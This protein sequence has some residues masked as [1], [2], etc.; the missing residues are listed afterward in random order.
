VRAAQDPSSVYVAYQYFAQAGLARFQ[1]S[2]P[3]WFSVAK[4]ETSAISSLA[5]DGLRV[6][7]GTPDAVLS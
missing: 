7:V 2:P 3:Q 4:N 5:A 1:K 6:Y